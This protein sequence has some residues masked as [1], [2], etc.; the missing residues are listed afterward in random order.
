MAEATEDQAGSKPSENGGTDQN[1][2]LTNLKLSDEARKQLEGNSELLNALTHNISAKRAANSE[3]KTVREEL[4]SL[5]KLKDDEEKAKLKEKGE[6]EKLYND[7]LKKLEE[8]K[9]ELSRVTIKNQV[10]ILGAKKGVK[11]NEYLKMFD[12]SAFNVDENFQVTGLETAFETF[13]QENPDLFG[14][15]QAGSPP[16]IE[17]GKPNLAAN[18]VN[19]SE[20]QELEKL[21][22]TGNAR[23]I[24]RLRTFKKEHNILN[25]R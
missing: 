14:V 17:S 12:S 4:Q 18:N 13:A 6:F 20:L 10:D 1:D 5:K 11:K 2:V 19:Q 21:A 24:A 9:N 23:H 15:S 22:R 3:A 7:S 16:S 8:Q 25:R